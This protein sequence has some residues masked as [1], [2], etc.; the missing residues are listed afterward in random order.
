MKE[1]K[2]SDDAISR[3]I[4]MIGAGRVAT[5]LAIALHSAG[6]RIRQVYSRTE[7]SAKILADRLSVS[8][9]TSIDQLMQGADVYIISLTD[10]ALSQL[11]PQ[12][13]QVCGDALIVHTAGSLNMDVLSCARRGVLYPMQTFSLERIVDFQQ[14][15]VFIEASTPA[16]LQLLRSISESISSSVYTLSSDDRQ[17]LHI[18]AVFCCNFTNHCYSI[19]DSL[20]SQMGVP[21]SVMLPLIDE[22]AQKVHFMAPRIGQTGPAVRGDKVVTNRHQ[23]MLKDNPDWQRIYEIMS[24][25]IEKEKN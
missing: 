4:V 22:T 25:D 15:P 21:F 24:R 17:R 18:A 5:S 20:L 10:T 11:A 16:D 12:I 1:T 23:E 19:A 13:V 9:T 7:Q 14:V 3:D 6:H 8:Y 2:N